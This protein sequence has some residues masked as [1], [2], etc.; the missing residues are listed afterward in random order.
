MFA[1]TNFLATNEVDVV[2]VNW[3]SETAGV[4]FYP[5]YKTTQR[6]LKAKM[7]AESPTDQWSS[8]DVKCLYKTS[9]YC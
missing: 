7:S 6:I 8:H 2:P 4:C 9:E 1:V 5:P 3:L